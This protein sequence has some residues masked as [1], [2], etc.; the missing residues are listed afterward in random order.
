MGHFLAE[1]PL[2]QAPGADCEAAG[3]AYGEIKEQ[4]GVV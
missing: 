3:E 2:F 1:H 4:Q